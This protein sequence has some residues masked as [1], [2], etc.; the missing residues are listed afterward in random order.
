[1]DKPTLELGVNL[2]LQT[3]CGILVLIMNRLTQKFLERLNEYVRLQESR[4]RL[5][6]SDF[7]FSGVYCFVAVLLFSQKTGFSSE[8]AIYTLR[9]TASILI[10]GL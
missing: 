9:K 1:M 7:T 10:W 6:G 2:F 8:K 3:L 5:S 4:N